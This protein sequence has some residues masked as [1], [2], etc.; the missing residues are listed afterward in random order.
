MCAQGRAVKPRCRNEKALAGD[1]AGGPGGLFSPARRVEKGSNQRTKGPA[2]TKGNKSKAEKQAE[3]EQAKDNAAMMA[4]V[5]IR[6]KLRREIKAKR[7][8]LTDV[9]HAIDALAEKS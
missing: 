2:M 3:I 4:M 5:K 8:E 1:E 6:L 9:N 7:Q